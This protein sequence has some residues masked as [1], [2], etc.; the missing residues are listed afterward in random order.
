MRLL[1]LH[2]SR[3]SS[4]V[5]CV[6][7]QSAGWK[8]YGSGDV[9]HFD[10]IG[11]PKIFPSPSHDSRFM[12]PDR[13]RDKVERMQIKYKYSAPPGHLVRLLVYPGS[14]IEDLRKTNLRG[15]RKSLRMSFARSY[16]KNLCIKDELVGEAILI[17][18]SINSPRCVLCF[19]DLHLASLGKHFTAFQIVRSS[20]TP[21]CLFNRYS[22]LWLHLISPSQS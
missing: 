1:S 11:T 20:S 4:L 13:Y 16:M 8:W 18:T 10:F 17:L 22:L 7:A 5:G 21:S 12:R 14:G 19:L 9:V 6:C 3:S 2:R 15:V